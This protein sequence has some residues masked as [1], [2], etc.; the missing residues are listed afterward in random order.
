MLISDNDDYIKIE[1][2]KVAKEADEGKCLVYHAVFK[3]RVDRFPKIRKNVSIKK[4]CI[5]YDIITMNFIHLFINRYNS[6][7]IIIFYKKKIFYISELVQISFDKTI[8]HANV[9]KIIKNV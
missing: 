9:L 5:K 8:S 3:S 7:I 1:K 4:F 2:C 6:F